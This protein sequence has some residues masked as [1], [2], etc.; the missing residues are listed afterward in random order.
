MPLQHGHTHNELVL[1]LPL[2]RNSLEVDLEGEV[3]LGLH[4]YNV[5][6][7]YLL[8]VLCRPILAELGV[9]PYRDRYENER[10]LLRV[11]DVQRDAIKVRDR[12]VD[13]ARVVALEPLCEDALDEDV[14][15]VEL[16]HGR[17]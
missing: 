2:L 10:P 12:L 3:V 1:L 6:A 17:C 11:G 14:V 9:A 7:V 15:V 4:F 13:G 5:A 8:Q 16:E